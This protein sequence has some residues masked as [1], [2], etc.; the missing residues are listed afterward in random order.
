MDTDGK[1]L[2][3]YRRWDDGFLV[4]R[5]SLEDERQVYKWIESAGDWAVSVDL[6]VA[7][8][9]RGD[10]D[11]FCVGEL[12]GEMIASIVVTQVA[13]DLSYI[14]HVY[15]VEQYRKRGFAR[16]M[17]TAAHDIFDR[18][19]WMGI[20]GFDTMDYMQSMYEK[21]GYKSAYNATVYQGPAPAIVDRNFG[22]D[23]RLVKNC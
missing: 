12:N 8:D 16:R 20:F 10:N 1:E 15:V 4:R 23:I 7:F 11:G 2:E 13:D 21:F 22:T 17:F 18:R 3:V 5:M 6:E 14:S 9:M 19:N